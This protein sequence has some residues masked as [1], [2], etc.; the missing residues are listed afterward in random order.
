[1]TNEKV[2]SVRSPPRI[3]G[4][5]RR[6]L[7]FREKKSNELTGTLGETTTGPHPPPPTGDGTP[8]FSG[9]ILV[10]EKVVAAET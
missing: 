2:E 10:R 9:K 5:Q 7:S 6:E 1:V 4:A 3:A 8:S